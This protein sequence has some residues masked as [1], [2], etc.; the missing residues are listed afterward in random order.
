[1]EWT[2]NECRNGAN[3]SGPNCKH[4]ANSFIIIDNNNTEW[5]CQL[6]RTWVW[7]IY[8]EFMLQQEQVS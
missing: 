7:T 3:C 6:Y 8:D 1:M 2:I 5:Y 4:C